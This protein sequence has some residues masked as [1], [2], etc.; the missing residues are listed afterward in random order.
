[1]IEMDV[2][3]LLQDALGILLMVC[4]GSLAVRALV[5]DARDY[6]ATRKARYWQRRARDWRIR[7]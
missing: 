6:W 1:M 5:I 3:D 7:D 2:G 4:I